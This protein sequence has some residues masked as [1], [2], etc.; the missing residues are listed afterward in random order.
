[1][2]TSLA[3]IAAT[4]GCLYV[5]DDV[6]SYEGPHVEAV[7]IC[8]DGTVTIFKGASIPFLH[9]G[10]GKEVRIRKIEVREAFHWPKTLPGYEAPSRDAAQSDLA[11]AV[12]LA[13]AKWPVPVPVRAVRY[14]PTNGV[15]EDAS[16]IIAQIALTD[17]ATHVITVNAAC[18]WD[19]GTA[20]DALL[21]AVLAHEMGHVLMGPEHSTDPESIMFP[22]VSASGQRVTEADKARLTAWMKP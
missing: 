19:A 9:D 15:C 21:V 14:G 13:A 22:S 5:G 1:M 18:P 4:D 10:H 16:G 7:R 8:D 20:S 6:G 12:S 11:L 2:A 3:A 17:Y